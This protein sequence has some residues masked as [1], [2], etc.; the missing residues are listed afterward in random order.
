MGFFGF[1]QRPMACF[2][3]HPPLRADAI[4]RRAY[5]LPARSSFNPHPPLRADAMIIIRHSGTDGPL[6]QSSPALT[7]G[8]YPRTAPSRPARRDEFQSSPALTGGCYPAKKNALTLDNSVSILTR[9]Y[10]RMLL[11][12]RLTIS[13]GIGAF[14]SSPALTGGCYSADR[15][16]TCPAPMFQSSPALTG[17]CYSP[18]PCRPGRR[19]EFQSSPALTGGCYSVFSFTLLGLPGFNPHPP[20]RA[21]AIRPPYADTSCSSQFQSSP[22]LTGGCYSGRP[23]Q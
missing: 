18:A 3:P 13:G 23:R 14:Q 17:G 12:G 21:D 22:A 9:P 19:D 2:N 8:C 11:P 10:G 20:L 1:S 7:G 15:S 16:I 4:G 6:F 5:P